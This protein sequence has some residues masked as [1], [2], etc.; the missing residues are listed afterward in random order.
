MSFSSV[1]DKFTTMKLFFVENED[2]TKTKI[3]YFDF[4]RRK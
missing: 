3:G 4:L 1:N 2:Q